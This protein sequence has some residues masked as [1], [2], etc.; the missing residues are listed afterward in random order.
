MSLNFSE[1]QIAEFKTAFNKFDKDGNSS[2]SF[3]EL[4]KIMK[5]LEIDVNDSEL[6]EMVYLYL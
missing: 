1:K 2:I 4:G 5:Y 6:K 3:E